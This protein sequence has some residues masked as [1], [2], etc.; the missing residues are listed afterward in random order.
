LCRSH[1]SSSQNRHVGIRTGIQ[2]KL[3]IM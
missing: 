1:F 3:R 2:I